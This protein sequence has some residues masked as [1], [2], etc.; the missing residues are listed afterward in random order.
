[1]E[2]EPFLTVSDS[3]IEKCTQIARTACTPLDFVEAVAILHGEAIGNVMFWRNGEFV[4]VSVNAC[5]VVTGHISL[6]L[7]AMACKPL[8]Q[9]FVEDYHPYD[10][11]DDD[12]D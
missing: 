2:I 3:T 9:H 12:E 5:K 8:A 11:E 6:W 1:M 7:D 4:T 10:S